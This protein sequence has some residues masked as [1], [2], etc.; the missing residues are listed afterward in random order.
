MHPNSIANLK[1]GGAKTRFQPGVS[2]NP[3]GKP[4]SLYDIQAAARK[5][6]PEA[7][8]TIIK[9]MED[10]KTAPTLK[11]KCAEIVL[12]RAFGKAPMAVDV[13]VEHK[14]DHRHLHLQA[15]ITVNKEFEAEKQKNLTREN[16]KAIEHNPGTD[17]VPKW[18][19]QHTRTTRLMNQIN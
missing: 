19:D 12:E 13:D 4:R 1:K 17:A 14:I 11:F 16:D 8:K 9:V 15:L 10:E 18:G 6:S 5:K 2:G 3:G 7:F